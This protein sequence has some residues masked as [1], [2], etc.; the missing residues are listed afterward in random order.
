MIFERRRDPVAP[1]VERRGGMD[2]REQ[3]DRR[4]GEDR[5]RAF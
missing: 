2:R 4:S 1:L 5:R 3:P